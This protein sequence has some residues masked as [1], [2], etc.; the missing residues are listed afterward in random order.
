MNMGTTARRVL[1]AGALS[2]ACNESP[3]VP[4]Q[5]TWANVEPIVRGSCTGCHG[6]NAATA[7]LSYRL[8]FFDMTDAVCGKAAAAL[9]GAPLASAWAALMAR[10]VTSPGSGWRSRMPP[11]PSDPLTDWER[12][13]IVR[14]AKAPVRGVPVRDNHRPDIQLDA[15]SATADKSMTFNAVVSD[16]DGESVVGVLTFGK[17]ELLMDRSGS[18]RQTVDTSGWTNGSY[19]INATLCDGWDSVTYDLG[20]V[21]VAHAASMPSAPPSPP[22]NLDAT[23]GTGGQDGAVADGAVA[24]GGVEVSGE[25][26]QRIALG[27][28]HD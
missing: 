8:D 12:E 19:P 26:A 6:S 22:S 18:F 20:N 28:T 11:A 16:A 10:D 4:D 1:A 21:L 15:A 17:V 25:G 23:S 3:Q 24:D 2:I 5:P 27:P 9:R 7:G 14:W 13:T